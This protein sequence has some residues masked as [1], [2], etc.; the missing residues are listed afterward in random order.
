MNNRIY[1]VLWFFNRLLFQADE[2]KIPLQQ[3]AVNRWWQLNLTHPNMQS[4][5]RQHHYRKC[6]YTPTSGCAKLQRLIYNIGKMKFECRKISVFDD[7]FGCTVTLSENEDKWSSVLDIKAVSVMAS[8]EQYVLLQ[9]TFSEDEFE[10]D[11]YYIETNDPEI[12]GELTIFSIYLYRT[13]LSMT[14]GNE[15]IEISF[16]VNDS[17]F[18]SLKKGLKKFTGGIGHL[19]FPEQ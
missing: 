12:S 10:S 4:G 16:N 8:V 3:Q 9:R 15:L 11:Y 18:E 2:Y 5:I 17:E 14:Y 6:S 19:I 1:F 7:E 13:H